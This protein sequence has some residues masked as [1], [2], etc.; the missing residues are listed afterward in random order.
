MKDANIRKKVLEENAKAHDACAHFHHR[1]VSYISRKSTRNFIWNM[2]RRE[3]PGGMPGR[4]VLEVGCG[5]G[6]FVSLA[7]EDRA[8][9]YVGIDLSREMVKEANVKKPAGFDAQF[10]ICSLED[11]AKGHRRKFD[12][13]LASSFLHHLYDI[14]EG[15]SQIR[16]MLVTGGIFICLHELI[17]TQRRNWIENFDNVLQIA[18]I[19]YDYKRPFFAK[20]K[21][22]RREVRAYGLFSFSNLRKF[23]NFLILRLPCLWRSTPEQRTT[24]IRSSQPTDTIDWVDYQLNGNYDLAKVAKNDTVNRK[25]VPYCFYNF[26]FLNLLYR[27]HNHNMF[28]MR[29]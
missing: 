27:R 3:L 1:S 21:R 16:S 24:E 10:E 25:V 23:F 15:L 4:S 2:I 9:N 28:I 5:T 6:T 18:S 22:F 8:E 26:Q 14:E 7:K 17:D 12:I 29:K 11:F 19:D 13:I 20:V